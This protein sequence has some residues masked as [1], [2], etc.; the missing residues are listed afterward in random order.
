MTHF[1]LFDGIASVEK[2]SCF[3]SFFLPNVIRYKLIWMWT[4]YNPQEVFSVLANQHLEL[5]SMRTILK[6]LQ[7]RQIT[8]W[9]SYLRTMEVTLVVCVWLLIG[10]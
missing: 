6:T 9:G 5:H 3:G 8:C 4:N 10:N 1:L 2:H 7:P